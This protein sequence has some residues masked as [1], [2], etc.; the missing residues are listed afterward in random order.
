M[1]GKKK[2]EK[3]GSGITL[4]NNEKK[5]IMKV[6]KCLENTGILIKRTN[7]KINS[8]EGGFLNFLRALMTTGLP[9]M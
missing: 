6:I 2:K 1:I 5:D 9:L 4:T 3:V 8:Q 7:K